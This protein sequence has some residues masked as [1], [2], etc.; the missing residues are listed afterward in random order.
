MLIDQLVEMIGDDA[1][2]ALVT[3]SPGA[4]VRIPKTVNDRLLEI[5]N[6][7]ERAARKLAYAFG[8]TEINVPV[9]KRWRMAYLHDRKKLSAVEIALA[10]SL[11][12]RSVRLGLKQFKAKKRGYPA[13]GEVA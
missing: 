4:M 9:A 7:D 13:E 12:D 2:M 3:R 11:S 5:V 6:G 8:G 10:L 1:T